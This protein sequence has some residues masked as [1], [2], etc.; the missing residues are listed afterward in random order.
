M[1]VQSVIVVSALS[2]IFGIGLAYF[3]KKFAV[4]VDERVQKVREILPG[5]NCGS[6]GLAGCDAFAEAVAAGKVP[7][8]GCIPGQKDVA[9]KIAAI[10]GTGEAAAKEKKVAQLHCNGT[11]ENCKPKFDY[12]GIKTCKAASIIQSGYKA[13]SYA[14]LGFGD[15]VLVCPV[16]AI[17]MKSNGLPVVDKEKCIS[18]GKCV[19]ECPKALYDL[20]PK[21]NKIHVLC[22]S[23]DPG[24]I[25]TK[26]CKVGC[27]AC[28][29]CEKACKFD[30]IHVTDNLAKIDYKKC[31][32]CGACVTACPRKIIVNENKK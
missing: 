1:I 31:T 30:A 12:D 29:L 21:K 4:E 7:V 5:V 18:C 27:I 25:V 19:K 2:F 22:S 17:S 15:C 32:Q 10:L 13:C 11:K 26:V 28:K 8:D 3:A 16:N 23:K 6:C 9:D 14:C 20:V 24:K